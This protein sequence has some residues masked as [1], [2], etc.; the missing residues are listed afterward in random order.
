M[1]GGTRPDRYLVGIP[2][3]VLAMCYNKCYHNSYL[4]GIPDVQSWGSRQGLTK[5]MNQLVEGQV[6]V[7]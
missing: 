7:S 6:N 2:E 5:D 3:V 1:L 4:A